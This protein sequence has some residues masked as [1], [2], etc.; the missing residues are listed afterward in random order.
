[1]I[2][3]TVVLE[4]ENVRKQRKRRV[5]CT[6]F[7]AISGSMNAVQRVN[8]CDLCQSTHFAKINK[9][10]ADVYFTTNAPF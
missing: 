10:C 9:I 6:V 5:E 2:K 1:M 4:V 8:V 3:V 7:T